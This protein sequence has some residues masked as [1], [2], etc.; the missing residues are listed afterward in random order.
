MLD[1]RQK[2]IVVWTEKESQTGAVIT[3]IFRQPEL[4]SLPTINSGNINS[5]WVFEFLS[6]EFNTQQWNLKISCY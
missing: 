2:S 3:P 5:N 6:L 4:A 1:K